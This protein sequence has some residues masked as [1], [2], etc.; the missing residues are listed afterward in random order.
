MFFENSLQKYKKTQSEAIFDHMWVVISVL[1]PTTSDIWAVLV[2]DTDQICD[3]E[4]PSTCKASQLI[5]NMCN[6]FYR[7]SPPTREP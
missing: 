1:L 5:Q 7:S 4:W 3:R 2:G 6:V